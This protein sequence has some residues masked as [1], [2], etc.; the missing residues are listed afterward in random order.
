LLGFGTSFLGSLPLG[1]ISGLV[2]EIAAQKTWR[3][4]MIAAVGV[5]VVECLQAFLAVYGASFFTD[6][7]FLEILISIL[8]LPIFLILAYQHLSHSG[9]VAKKQIGENL[10]PFWQGAFVSSLNMAAF[11]YWILWGGI[12]LSQSWLENTVL[13]ITIFALSSGFGTLGAMIVY[14]FVGSLFKTQL[15]R[16]NLLVNR[17]MGILFLGMAVMQIWNLLK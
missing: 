3:R 2:M 13:S 8:G 12:F 7:P 11:A 9:K 1:V 10:S 5:S 17:A 14:I 16:Y 4:A 15:Q 6:Y